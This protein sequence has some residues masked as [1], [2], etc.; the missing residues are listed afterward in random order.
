MTCPTNNVTVTGG[1]LGG[2]GTIA[3]AV[4][5]QTG[6]TLEPGA[7]VSAAGTVLTLS[8]NLTLNAGSTNIM[9]VSH[10]SS[11]SDSVVSSLAITYGGTLTVVTNAGDAPFVLGDTFTL[12]TSSV[13]S[14]NGSFTV[15]NLPA[16]TPGLA[17]NTANL[18]VNGTISVVTAIPSIGSIVV[19]GGNL[20]LT[21]T[22]G[23][24]GGQ[25]IVLTSTNLAVPV[26]QWTPLTTNNY[27]G[28]GS[29][30]YTVTGAI[31][32]GKPQ[33]FYRLLTQ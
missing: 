30:S 1:T 26:S 14:Y 2:S 12:F 9:Q 27:S 3:G 17:W 13:P 5:V 25:V 11:T 6:G 31:T 28:T 8:S 23:S 21:S 22:N 7:S 32:S 4:T 29:F 10:N 19:S 20:T 33:Q 15:F 16:L 24:A 18:T